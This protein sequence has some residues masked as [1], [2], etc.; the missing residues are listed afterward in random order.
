MTLFVTLPFYILSSIT[1]K[2]CAKLAAEHVLKDGSPPNRHICFISILLPHAEGIVISKRYI[3]A[4]LP[5]CPALRKMLISQ[6][7]VTNPSTFLRKTFL[8]FTAAGCRAHS[9]VFFRAS[10]FYLL[11]SVLSW[12]WCGRFYCC[13]PSASWGRRNSKRCTV[14]CPRRSSHP[15]QL[16]QTTTTFWYGEMVLTHT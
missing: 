1:F 13:S 11:S 16:S 7:F 6:R 14:D 8:R 9:I 4:P 12:S 3:I 10:L 2:N 15:T 5:C